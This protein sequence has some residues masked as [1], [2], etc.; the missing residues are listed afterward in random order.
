M[1]ILYL[2][3]G[4]VVGAL[5]GWLWG[6]RRAGSDPARLAAAEE[7]AKGEA[8]RRADAEAKLSAA[9]DAR[10]AVERGLAA[11]EEQ[12]RQAQAA[13][14]EQRQSVEEAR[15]QMESVFK[16]A[17]GEALKGNNEQFLALAK[18]RLDVGH[19]LAASDLQARQTAIEGLLKPLRETLG[20]LETQTQEIEKARV[21]AY[22]MLGQHVEALSKAAQ[23]IQRET[24]TLS[25]ALKSS[26]VRGRWGEIALRNVI[27]L[28][29]MTEHCDFVEQETVADR[30]RPDVIVRL[31]GGRRIAVDAK[32]S[33]SAYMEAAEA[34]VEAVRTKALERHAVAVRGRMDELAS[35]AYGAALGEG[36]V[37]VVMFLPGEPFL[38]AA[39]A[40][41]PELMSDAWSKNVL[42]ATP[43][44]LIA[45]LR[46][47]AIYHQQQSLAVNAQQIASEARELHDRARVFTEHLQSM[48]EGLEGA[49]A[50]Y[51]KAVRSYE[52]RLLPQG[53]E[54]ER[55]L[56]LERA[57]HLDPPAPI[58]A[59]VQRPRSGGTTT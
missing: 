43:T 54:L 52:G 38:S 27:E 22:A 1:E 26:Q 41:D 3:L 10:V 48:G 12:A 55:L 42:V 19:Q 37:L 21:G 6:S 59:A 46:T 11:A 7:R 17:A 18:Q 53:R 4:L 44:T 47:V 51:N 31:P 30:G 32:A 16:V 40:T 50:A 57:K 45:L 14:A 15:V 23:G 2:F 13:L 28:A 49:L 58:E 39:F 9:E 34:T 36:V 25:T 29:G 56:A 33:M 35:K 24:V 20:K 8:E 5:V